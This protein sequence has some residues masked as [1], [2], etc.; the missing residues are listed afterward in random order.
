MEDGSPIVP[1][2]AKNVNANIMAAI[3]VDGIARFE[4]GNTLDKI[5]LAAKNAT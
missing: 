3:T 5:R 1:M 2:Y 4:N